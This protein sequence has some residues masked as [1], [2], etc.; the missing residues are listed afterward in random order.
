MH[1]CSVTIET[2]RDCQI[3]WI[4]NYRWLWVTIWVLGT[5]EIFNNNSIYTEPFSDVTKYYPLH[6]AELLLLNQS[7]YSYLHETLTK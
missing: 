6:I 5:T 2:I 1:M 7:Y 3:L 4:W